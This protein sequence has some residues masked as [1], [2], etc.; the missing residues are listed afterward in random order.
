[1]DLEPFVLRI[2]VQEQ[3]DIRVWV[4]RAGIRLQAERKAVYL[5]PM[6]HL[7]KQGGCL[8]F[9]ADDSYC[10]QKESNLCSLVTIW[11]D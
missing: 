3:R 7:G 2:T 4:W 11:E 9:L 8:F 1:M 10:L 6:K 5:Q